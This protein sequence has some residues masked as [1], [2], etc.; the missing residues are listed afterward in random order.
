MTNH[1]ISG[2]IKP[3][4]LKFGSCKLQGVK[5]GSHQRENLV[6]FTDK[7][8]NAN[9]TAKIVN[10]VY[11]ADN[12][13]ANNEQFW[14]RRFRSGIFDVKDAVR[15]GRPVVENVDKITEIIIYWHVGSRSITQEL[16]IDHKTVLS[17]LRKPSP[18]R[19]ERV[20]QEQSNGTTKT[21]YDRVKPSRES[22]RMN[23]AEL[24][25]DGASASA[26]GA[27][28]IMQVDAFILTPDCASINCV[29]WSFMKTH[30]AAA[31]AR[32]TT[33]FV[34]NPFGFS[35]SMMSFSFLGLYGLLIVAHPVEWL[36]T[37]TAVPLGQGSNPGE[38]M[39]VCK[40]RVPS[41]PGDTLNSR[42]AASSLVWWVGGRE[43][44]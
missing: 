28:E 43:G 26:A 37:L 13:T 20:S 12:V 36:A 14:F 21:P 29:R 9:Q 8:E 19:L 22:K 41:H 31:S 16:N 6:H 11:D 35:V 34:N 5:K 42:R 15:T 3:T 1:D 7:G 27:V 30:W 24:I 23:A 38:D 17:H 2:T 44:E 33:T 18:I 32:F 39:D 25:N 4:D 40:C 10:G